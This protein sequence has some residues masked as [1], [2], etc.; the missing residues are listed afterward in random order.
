MTTEEKI[1]QE[2][3][4]LQN[5]D[6]SSFPSLFQQARNLAKQAWLS[7]SGAVKGVAFLTS[8]E[9][10]AARLAICSECEFFKEPRCLKCGCYMDKKTHL[11]LAGCPENKWGKLT[12]VVYP[13]S[14]HALPEYQKQLKEN[15]SI[16]QLNLNNFSEKDRTEMLNLAEEALAFDGR[17]NYNKTPYLAYR[18]GAGDI[19]IKEFLAPTQIKSIANYTEAEK[20]EFESLISEYK[21]KEVKEFEFKNEKFKITFDNKGRLYVTRLAYKPFVTS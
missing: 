11:E 3:D 8:A 17:F 19:L 14:A 9:T 21:F 4:K 6:I 18:D 20:K 15:E 1:Q 12:T 5:E 10:A 7:G 2:K 16:M 13:K